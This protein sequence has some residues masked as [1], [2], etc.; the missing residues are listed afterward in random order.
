MRFNK[1]E[2]LMRVPNEVPKRRV[3]LSP[4]WTRYQWANDFGFAP[5]HA[6]M[7]RIR[8]TDCIPF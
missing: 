4:Y 3:I 1:L 2:I 8:L 5:K 6:I 7:P